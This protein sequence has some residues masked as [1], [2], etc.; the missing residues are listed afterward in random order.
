MVEA[1]MRPHRRGIGVEIVVHPFESLLIHFAEDVGASVIMRGLRAVADFE[2][3][4]QM[5][6][7]NRRDERRDRDG[8]PDGRPAPPGDRLAPG[9]GDRA[10]RRRRHRASCP[11]A[12]RALAEKFGAAEAG[13]AAL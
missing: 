8:V 12:W 6:G 3:E 11:S 5:A 2:Y 10:P 1:E 7:M 4:F 9:Q 13:R